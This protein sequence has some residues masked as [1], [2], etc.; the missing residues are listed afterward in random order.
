MFVDSHMDSFFM[1]TSSDSG[2]ESGIKTRC[3]WNASV[4]V[5][6]TARSRSLS[7][8]CFQSPLYNRSNP[9][10]WYPELEAFQIINFYWHG[11]CCY[12]AIEI[13]FEFRCFL[14]SMCGLYLF[15]NVHSESIANDG[16]KKAC[17]RS[18]ADIGSC[19]PTGF[20]WFW[21]RKWILFKI[22]LCKIIVKKRPSKN[23]KR[24]KQKTHTFIL[25][26][27]K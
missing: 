19:P 12:F 1:A 2:L 22:L 27:L 16:N 21:S 3:H 15:I 6:G 25:F 23:I 14:T 9:I 18:N 10:C 8:R 7:S 11:G 24:S 4:F 20:I 17:N 13:W 26:E 5:S